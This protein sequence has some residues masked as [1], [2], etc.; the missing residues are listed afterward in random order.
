M[1]ISPIPLAMPVWDRMHAL[2][3]RSCPSLPWQ[4][5][6]RPRYWACMPSCHPPLPWYGSSSRPTASGTVPKARPSGYFLNVRSL[7]ACLCL[8][9]V[10]RSANQRPIGL[11]WRILVGRSQA[12]LQTIE[13]FI[14]TCTSYPYM[15]MS[16]Y[17]LCA[18]ELPHIPAD[19][20]GASLEDCLHLLPLRHRHAF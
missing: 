3:S 1:S 16:S 9:S 4:R 19:Q 14:Y 6:P 5:R 2:Y 18:A 11:K 15:P 20:A 13:G 17:R 10:L 7:I 8:H 12:G